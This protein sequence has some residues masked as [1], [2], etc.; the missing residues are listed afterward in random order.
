MFL[1]VNFLI[2]FLSL[3]FSVS[4]MSEGMHPSASDCEGVSRERGYNVDCKA[5]E[6]ENSLAMRRSLAGFGEEIID[7]GWSN[8]LG[9]EYLELKTSDWWDY[10]SQH[11][12]FSFYG[13]GHGG[14]DIAG[15]DINNNLSVNDDVFSIDDGIVSYICRQEETSGADNCEGGKNDG[16]NL[17]VSR[18]LIT[19]KDS[20][21]KEFVA[22]YGH[23]YGESGLEIGSE[24]SAGQKIGKLKKYGSPVHI[25]FAII[26]RI[27]ENGVDKSTAWDVYNKDIQI[28]PEKFFIDRYSSTYDLNDALSLIHI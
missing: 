23:V 26:D 19:H 21:N 28:D 13:R 5:Y 25:H 12:I 16:S 14:L 6:L 24:V 8:I 11:Y 22:V 17:N 4:A 2:I 1:N 15:S 9:R 7:Q 20:N 10:N 3:I 27:P 18:V